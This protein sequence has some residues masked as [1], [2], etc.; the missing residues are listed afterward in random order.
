MDSYTPADT[1]L[2]D[3]DAPDLHWQY[4]QTDDVRFA[5]MAVGRWPSFPPIWAVLACYGEHEAWLRKTLVSA[6]SRSTS[7]SMKATSDS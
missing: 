4:R 1:D 3:P 6:I 5:A 7:G 2:L